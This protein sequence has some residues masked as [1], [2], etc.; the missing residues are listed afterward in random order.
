MTQV[1]DKDVGGLEV[2]MDD[3]LRVHRMQ[4]ISDL[5]AQPENGLDV[6]RMGSDPL[7]QGMAF[8]KLHGNEGATV[9]S[10]DF[11]YGANVRMIEG[12]G[13]LGFT[14]EAA[15]GFRIFCDRI[16]QKLE[17]DKAAEF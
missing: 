4:R 10:V 5:N 15:E 17:S 14:A 13:G 16:G 1:G 2:A 8:E 9:S 7:A 6:Q 12:R 3:A 11:V